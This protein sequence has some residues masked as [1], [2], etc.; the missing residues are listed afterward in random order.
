[1]YLAILLTEKPTGH[2]T[3]K[4]LLIYWT[5]VLL[6]VFLMTNLKSVI[7]S[8][9]RAR[10]PLEKENKL[11]SDNITSA[12]LNIPTRPFTI[13]EVGAVIKKSESKEGARL[14]FHNQSNTAGNGNKIHHPTM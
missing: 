6:E 9:I 3:I 14:Y 12:I 13:K 2:L 1:M 8:L 10:F 11:F 5:S 4:R 7:L